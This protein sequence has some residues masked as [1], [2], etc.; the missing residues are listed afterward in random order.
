MEIGLWRASKVRREPFLTGRANDR[1]PCLHLFA[2]W[3]EHVQSKS[4]H[5]M[6]DQPLDGAVQQAELAA[7][8]LE[9]VGRVDLGCML[10]GHAATLKPQP[11]RTRAVEPSLEAMRHRSAA[12]CSDPELLVALSE[13]RLELRIA[14]EALGHRCHAVLYL[15]ECG[16]VSVIGEPLHGPCPDLPVVDESVGQCCHIDP[17]FALHVHGPDSAGGLPA[18]RLVKQRAVLVHGRS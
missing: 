15:V 10:I 9:C 17:D 8:T 11:A 18:S 1:A 16:I 14:L 12:R 7:D 3:P 13:Q 5:D 2:A 6:G 4:S